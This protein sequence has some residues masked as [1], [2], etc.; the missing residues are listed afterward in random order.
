[1]HACVSFKIEDFN[2]DYNPKGDHARAKPL[3]GN[4][5]GYPDHPSGDNHS[6]PLGYNQALACAFWLRI[7]NSLHRKLPEE[8]NKRKYTSCKNCV[9]VRNFCIKFLTKTQFLQNLLISFIFYGKIHF[10]YF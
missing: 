3:I 10:I 2:K 4:P 8:T 6:N 1:L 9:F 5:L 7:G